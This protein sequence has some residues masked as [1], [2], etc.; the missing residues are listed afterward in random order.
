[1]VQNPLTYS[2]FSSENYVKTMWKTPMYVAEI[3]M[4]VDQIPV[5]VVG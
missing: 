5:V 1:M 2:C 4:Y 3:I